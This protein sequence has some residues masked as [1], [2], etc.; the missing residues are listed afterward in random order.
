[1]SLLKKTK[2]LKTKNKLKSSIYCQYESR[3]NETSSDI[4]ESKFRMF[5]VFMKEST[6]DDL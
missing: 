5:I 3:G 4:P 6:T 1:M 2:N